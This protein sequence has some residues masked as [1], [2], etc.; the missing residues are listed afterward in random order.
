MAEAEL[1]RVHDRLYQL[2]A[3]LEDVE[4]DLAE[5]DDS[6]RYRRAFEH[7]YRAVSDLA[8]MVVEPVRE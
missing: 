8:G 3:A 4:S 2:E 1:R 5:S 6:D 7:L